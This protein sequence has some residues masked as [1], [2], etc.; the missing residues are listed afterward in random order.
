MKLY[1]CQTLTIVFSKNA[2]HKF[3]LSELYIHRVNNPVH[4]WMNHSTHGS[5]RQH[6]TDDPHLCFHINRPT[7]IAH[8]LH[9]YYRDI[10]EFLHASDCKPWR[11]LVL[12]S[13][14]MQLKSFNCQNCTYTGLILPCTGGW[15]TARTEVFNNIWRMIR[16][17]V[18]MLADQ[19][20]WQMTCMHHGM[21]T[22][23]AQVGALWME[24]D[25]T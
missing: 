11:H 20:L 9:A 19:Q 10:L 3:Q 12:Y 24:S 21:M 1:T 2:T 17:C 8:D 14:Q 23:L 15:T 22:S 7:I 5:F 4:W 25:I 16:V 6:L 18:F 13:I